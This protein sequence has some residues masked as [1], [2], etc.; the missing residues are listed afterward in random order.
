MFA[1]ILIPLAIV[2]AVLISQRHP[3]P[4]APSIAARGAGSGAPSPIAVLCVFLQHNQRPPDMVIQCA[5]AEAQLLGR[6]DLVYDLTRAFGPAGGQIAAPASSPN[7]QIAKQQLSSP[8]APD[9]AP[10]APVPVP[11]EDPY[12]SRPMTQ[13]EQDEADMRAAIAA[14]GAP[15]PPSVASPAPEPMAPMAPVMGY[16]IPDDFDLDMPATQSA[17]PM[18]SFAP[19]PIAGVP[20]SAWSHFCGQLVREEPTFTSQRNVGRY[21]HRRDRVAAV[22]FNPDAIV[23]SI[24]AQDAVLA[25]DL[26]DAY[27]HMLRAGDLKHVGRAISIPDVDGAIPA[28]LSG[29]LGIAA[30]AGVDGCV[31]W[32]ENKADRKRFPHT[33]QAFLRCNGAF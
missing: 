18:P 28:T 31:G 25:A 3:S 4:T 14:Q 26:A 1:L 17:A 9:A 21:R 5:I 12:R 15:M 13:A 23:G 2:G 10:A 22:G 32:L 30:V 19:S 16:A 24:E 29:L 27:D 33:T 6:N 20:D 8:I 7:R 11:T